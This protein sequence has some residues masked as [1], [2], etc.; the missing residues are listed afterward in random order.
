MSFNL[1][2]LFAAQLVV[3]AV[4]QNRTFGQRSKSHFSTIT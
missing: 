4:E 2:A 3:D 1:P